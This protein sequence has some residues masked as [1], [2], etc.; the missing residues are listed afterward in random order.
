MKRRWGK[1]EEHYRRRWEQENM[2]TKKEKRKR[3]GKEETGEEQSEWGKSKITIAK[4]DAAEIVWEE[5]TQDKVSNKS[6]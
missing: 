4:G 5:R 6:K 2:M 1:K 3:E